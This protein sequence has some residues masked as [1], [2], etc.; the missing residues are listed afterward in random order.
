[1][2][3]CGILFVL[4]F[5]PNIVGQVLTHSCTSQSGVPLSQLLALQLS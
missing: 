4:Q 3:P 1:M 2:L 5:F